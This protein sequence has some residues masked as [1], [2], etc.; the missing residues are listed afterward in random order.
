MQAGA[1]WH[2][3]EDAALAGAGRR[4]EGQCPTHSLAQALQDEVLK[5]THVAGPALLDRGGKCR[6]TTVPAV[7]FVA[8][9]DF[10]GRH[11]TLDKHL[12][13]LPY[14]GPRLQYP[15]LPPNHRDCR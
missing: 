15:R 7:P 1:V 2:V 10:L 12:A 8:A 3:R 9:V 4:F 11:A 5:L 6:L 14:L 13:G